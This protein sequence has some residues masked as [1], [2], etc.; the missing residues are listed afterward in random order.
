MLQK[1]V[2]GSRCAIKAFL[3]NLVENI[4]SRLSFQIVQLNPILVLKEID[5]QKLKRCKRFFIEFGTNFQLFGRVLGSGY[6]N[7][8]KKR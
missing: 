1:R 4:D 6:R 3:T 8:E 7:T 2:I 5:M